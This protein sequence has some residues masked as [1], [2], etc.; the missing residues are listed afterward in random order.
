[1]RQ[2]RRDCRTTRRSLKPLAL[3]R[4]LRLT[5][6]TM[7]YW[8][9]EEGKAAAFA[10]LPLQFPSKASFIPPGNDVLGLKFFFGDLIYG[11]R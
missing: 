2:S 7:R 4:S 1:M 11:Q 8:F 6:K 3:R 5:W 10:S 9:F